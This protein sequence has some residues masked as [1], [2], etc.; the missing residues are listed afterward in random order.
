[1]TRNTETEWQPIETAP[2]DGTPV[3]GF[4]GLTAGDEPPDM[5]VTKFNPESGAWISTEVPFE[6]FDTPTHW[7][8][9]PD[10]PKESQS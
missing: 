5:A 1:M 10:P 7:M 3:L 6:E 8:P 4:F 2:K 9:L